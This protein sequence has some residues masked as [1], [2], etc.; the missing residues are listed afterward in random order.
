MEPVGLTQL[1]LS[2]IAAVG[3]G[4]FVIVILVLF[5]VVNAPTIISQLIKLKTDKDSRKASGESS[6][7]V[8]A[9]L[10][11]IK[12][13]SEKSLEA[14]TSTNASVVSLSKSIIDLNDI[15]KKEDIERREENVL[16]TENIVKI[17]NSLDS[18]DKMMR[19]V[20]SEK[21]MMRVVGLKMGIRNNFKNDLL[22]RIIDNID[23][24]F[25]T[26]D[27]QL[28][29]NLKSDLNSAWVDL[30][31]EFESFNA[32]I[33]IKYFLD[34]YEEEL[35]KQ[36]GMFQQIINLAISDLEKERKKEAISKQIDAGTRKIQ[37]SISSYLDQKRK[38][39]G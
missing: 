25:E 26:K 32:P 30:K 3:V 22:N 6:A 24:L 7:I 19:N 20:M 35:W 28:S 15:S 21:D 23:S 1:V 16:I 4:N 31:N 2:L 38:E 39:R 29:Y 36:D 12:E 8:K 10:I 27:G 5:I 11:D 14:T 13:H 34:K 9:Q 33:N 18:I 17:S 37:S